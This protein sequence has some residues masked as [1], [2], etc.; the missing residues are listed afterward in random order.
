MEKGG[1]LSFIRHILCILN[2]YTLI[3]IVTVWGVCVIM[4]NV[5]SVSG[6]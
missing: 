4:L 1:G 3:Y 2:V 5:Q 6:Y